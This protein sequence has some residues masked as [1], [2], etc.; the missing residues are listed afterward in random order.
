VSPART[1]VPLVTAVVVVAGLAPVTVVAGSGTGSDGF[2]TAGPDIPDAL[3]QGEPIESESNPGVVQTVEYRLLPNTTGR[4]GMTL[5]YEPGANI[6]SIV[7]YS[8]GSRTLVE[9]NGFRKQPNGRW[10]WTGG[11]ATP[12]LSFLVTVNRSGPAYH[13]LGWVDTGEWALARPRTAFAYRDDG[14]AWRYSWQDP[15]RIRQ[16]TRV[17]GD[18][19]V[20]SSIV[21]LGPHRTTEAR[22][23]HGTLRVVEPAAS[24]MTTVDPVVGTIRGASEQLRVGDSDEHV[25]LFVAP[26]PLR[27]GGLAINEHGESQD[28]WVSDREP[29]APPRNTWVHEYVHTRQSFDLGPGMRWFTEASAT[30]Y[31]GLLSV[32]QGLDGRQG[33]EAFQSTLQ[34]NYSDG[35]VLANRSDWHSDYTP[36]SRGT[37]TLAA[38]DARIRNDTG[39]NRTLQ[40]VFRRMNEH[41]G[42]VTYGDFSRMVAN[43]T[44]SEYGPWL[45]AHVAGPERVDVP[46]DP[47]VYTSPRDG[48]DAD[49]DGLTTAAERR[50][51]THPFD[52]DT[53]GDDLPDGYEVYAGTDPTDADTD[54]DGVPDGVEVSLGTNPTN[55][56]GYGGFGL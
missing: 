51:G 24:N 5:R 11:T 55:A 4:I 42:T 25:T 19:V 35:V 15:E 8:A 49:G 53:D 50:A 48:H 7:T 9:A 52:V 46:T 22:L 40:D 45:A 36:Y 6:T 27:D 34:R 30:Y 28:M 56:T 32:R 23:S 13:G 1:V 16:R 14:T 41:N 39:G 12:S 18:G 3:V 17:D 2:G 20:G 10:V 29:I 47:F 43:A 37:K 44:G 26:R 21:Y 54:D 33:Y 31:A 38:L